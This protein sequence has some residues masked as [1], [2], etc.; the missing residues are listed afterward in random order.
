MTGKRGKFRILDTDR[1]KRLSINEMMLTIENAFDIYLEE[2][3]ITVLYE[4]F[5]LDLNQ[6][7]YLTPDELNRVKPQQIQAYLQEFVAQ[8]PSKK[9]RFSQQVWLKP[10]TS[11]DLI[12]KKVQDRVQELMQVPT[13]LIMSS[14][15]QV[16][17]YGPHGHYN[18]HLDSSQLEEASQCCSEEVKSNCRLCRYAT[19]LFYLNDVTEGGETAFPLANNISYDIH[20]FREEHLVNLQRFCSKANLIVKPEKGKI[21]LWYNHFVDE[22]TGGLGA[23]D[24]LTWHGGCPVLQGEKW[25]ANFWIIASEKASKNIKSEP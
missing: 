18:A 7:M 22:E 14:S 21:I 1:D 3:D 9:S 17:R 12:F 16:V 11:T 2:E 13:E 24:E 23:L 25:V 19:I 15:F 8:S 20:K 10:S 6:D 4:N 5:N